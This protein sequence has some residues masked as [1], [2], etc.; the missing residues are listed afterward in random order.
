MQP[1]DGSERATM[2]K[3]PYREMLGSLMYAA[4]ATRP[5]IAYA[6]NTLARYQE[7]PGPAHF[8]ALK[9]IFAYLHA[10][11]NW[12]L[13][14]DA[15]NTPGPLVGFTDTDGH[16]TEGRHA[17]S[18]YVFTLN[19]GAVSWSSK[20]QELVTLST[21]EAKYVAQT[22][23]A[24][25]ALWLSM[26]RSEVLGRPLAPLTLYADNQGAIALACNDRFH[27]RTKHINIRYHFI[28]ELVEQKKILLAYV[29]S[30]SNVADI[31]TKA[32]A[33]PLFKHLAS[34]LGL[35]QA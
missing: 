28:R 18:G 23:A 13:T 7:N 11:A 20:R 1:K 17:I 35:R 12:C 26:L 30:V 29:P 21:T 8:T 34:K 19:G 10:T 5:D 22:H 2:S 33:S 14:Y 6:V 31:L 4:V 32:L 16:S 9:R 27:A 3:L 25:E 15:K 24:K